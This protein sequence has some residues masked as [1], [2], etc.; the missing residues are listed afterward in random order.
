M[1]PV[2]WRPRVGPRSG[3][4]IRVLDSSIGVSPPADGDRRR[5]GHDQVGLSPSLAPQDQICRVSKPFPGCDCIYYRARSMGQTTRPHSA[6]QYFTA[7]WTYFKP[8]LHVCEFAQAQQLVHLN[9]MP[10][11]HFRQKKGAC[12]NFKN[13]VAL[14]SIL[15]LHLKIYPTVSALANLLRF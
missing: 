13:T 8:G 11:P 3:A 10:C 5:A 6:V 9:G 12:N 7:W 4:N 1:L 14:E 2:H 15:L